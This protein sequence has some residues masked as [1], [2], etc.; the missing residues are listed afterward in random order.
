MAAL[1]RWPSMP[2]A[3]TL[4]YRKLNQSGG[5]SKLMSGAGGA[6]TFLA[7]QQANEASVSAFLDIVSLGTTT[8]KDDPPRVLRQRLISG[9]EGISR[10]QGNVEKLALYIKAWNAWRKHEMTPSLRWRSQG[11]R[12]EDFPIV[13][14]V[15]L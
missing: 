7:L 9:N 12:K 13:E 1:Q 5:S 2:A 3:V 15:K 6:F 8:K 10:S 4:A 11:E 14:D